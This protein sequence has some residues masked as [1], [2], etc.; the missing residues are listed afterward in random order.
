VRDR[1][2]IALKVGWALLV[3]CGVAGVI[4]Y[5]T[6]GR[7]A[8]DQANRAQIWSAILSAVV[9]VPPVLVGMWLALT[10]FRGPGMTVSAEQRASA[11]EHLAAK[12][13]TSWGEQARNQGITTTAPVAVR[14]RAGPSDLAP[15][16]VDLRSATQSAR[17]RR[18]SERES[19]V[20]ARLF[21]PATV[22]H[23]APS[24][25]HGVVTAWYDDLYA[26]MG[27]D[28]LVVLGAPGSG[29]SGALLLLLLEALRR[30][31][32]L[33]ANERVRVPV[34]VWVTCGSW[35]PTSTTLPRHVAT[36]L[37]RDY[38]GLSSIDH[39]GKPGPSALVEH[40]Q[41]A[42]FLDGLDEMPLDLRAGALD[43][44]TAQASRLPVVLTSRTDEYRTAT[45]S[46]RFRPAA[47]IELC[48]VDAVAAADFLVDRQPPGRVAAWQPIL[49]HLRGYPASPLSQVL[50]TP[51]GLALARDTYS[52]SDPAELLDP[53]HATRQAVLNS[54]LGAF[55]KH[56]YP[57]GKEHDQAVR[58][59][60]WIAQQ[61]NA[62]KSGALRDL[63]WWDIPTW[64]PNWQRRLTAGLTAEV[65]YGV[66]A[67][68]WRLSSKL[69]GGVAD[70]FVG[71]V[72]APVCAIAAGLMVG[73]LVRRISAPQVLVLR[74]PRAKEIPGMLKSGVMSGLAFNVAFE[75]VFGLE[76]PAFED[77]VGVAQFLVL[78]LPF[79]VPVGLVAALFRLWRTPADDSPV[80][81]PAASYIADH[82]AGLAFA[83][84]AGL[85]A[86][87][88]FGLATAL[89]YWE[90]ELTMWQ[91]TYALTTGLLTGVVAALAAGVTVGLTCGSARQVRFAQTALRIRGRGRVRFIPLLEDAMNRQVLRQAGAVYQF[92]HAELQEYFTEVARMP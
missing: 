69:P 66:V 28:V 17:V 80:A 50:A 61:M 67:G 34:P 29:K 52:S 21:V 11:A 18:E 62:D 3:L 12:S 5:V 70:E 6:A 58:W 91:Q 88:A 55:V 13:L 36:V 2:Q 82:R 68:L 84:A 71:A 63:R 23:S 20:A 89:V 75:L 10:R 25:T 77:W 51:L 7:T 57:M 37:A 90:D 40:G 85:V 8:V 47:V 14:W 15:E 39:G 53:G 31:H 59:L 27:S 44:I 19:R 9:I 92:R 87:L 54:I 73:L 33:P 38:P 64:I 1:L 76:G 56:A 30:Y 86:G 32:D 60:S 46:G 35:D 22:Q 24:L 83:L 81:T 4:T 72:G 42:V 43:A 65:S 48:P 26:R 74:R 16:V 41:I 79:A 49:T 78:G 45:S